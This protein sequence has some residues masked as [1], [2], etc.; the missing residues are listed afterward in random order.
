M[1][2]KSAKSAHAEFYVLLIYVLVDH[3]PQ[4]HSTSL[5][6]WDMA[7]LHDVANTAAMGKDSCL[8]CGIIHSLRFIVRVQLSQGSFAT[9]LNSK[10]ILG[11]RDIVWQL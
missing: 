5:K 11:Q 4:F 10:K 1:P 7:C 6:F 9:G 8:S 3:A 2:Y